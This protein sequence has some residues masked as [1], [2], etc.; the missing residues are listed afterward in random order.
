M[1]RRSRV[2]LARKLRPGLPTAAIERIGRRTGTF[3]DVFSVVSSERLAEAEQAGD[4]ASAPAAADAAI[5]GRVSQRKPSA[6]AAVLAWAGGVVHARQAARALAVIGTD[7]SSADYDVV[8]SSSLVRPA[9][10]A[11]PRLREQ[12]ADLAGTTRR[13]LAGPGTSSR[14]AA[15][16]TLTTR[17]DVAFWTGMSGDVAEALR[18]TRELLP[19]R[20][21]ALGPD[22]PTR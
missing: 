16:H 22:H 3:A 21:R 19:D 12:V 20:E 14:P 5:N 13:Q 4:E 8:R 17:H 10:A 9:D 18:L 11:S 7:A 6:E 2:S 1:E 15:P